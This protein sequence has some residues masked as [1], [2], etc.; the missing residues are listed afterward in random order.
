MARQ[1]HPKRLPKAP[2]AEVVFELRWDLQ[3]APD[4][5]P[6]LRSD[7]GLLPLLDSFS[8]EMK[9]IGF[10]A[11]HDM[12]PALQTGGYGVVRRFFTDAGRPFPIM[13]VGPGIFATN[14]ASEYEWEAFKGRVRHGLRALLKSYPH[15]GFFKLKPRHIELRYINVFDASLLGTT[16]LF[17]FL[18]RG[19]NMR[20]E[21]PEM[22][23]DKKIFSGEAGGR[24]V[25][26]RPLKG[27]KDSTFT[28]DIG[29]GKS[30]GKDDIIR[31]EIKVVSQGQSVPTVK[32]ATTFIP[33]IEEWLEF[34]HDITSPFFKHLVRPEL[35][36][37]FEE[38]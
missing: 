30:G 14:D 21:V 29:S 3:G 27:W 2:L 31:L 37:K 9:R 20:C 18:D 36:A 17:E 7:P 4:A 11:S 34:A 12:S 19:T 15:L 25:F 8:K 24:F 32:R 6:V 1:R 22:L 38:D 33:A 26:V 5:H 28:L 13:Q 16:A 35:M 10:P 23:N